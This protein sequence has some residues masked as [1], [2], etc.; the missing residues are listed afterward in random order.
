MSIRCIERGSDG[1]I[2]RVGC[3]PGYLSGLTAREHHRYEASNFSGLTARGLEKGVP[4]VDHP[5]NSK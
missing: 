4:E 3:Q 5:P 1:K 2:W